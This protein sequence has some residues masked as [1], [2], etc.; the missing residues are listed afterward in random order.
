VPANGRMCSPSRAGRRKMT[1]ISLLSPTPSPVVSARRPPHQ[2]GHGWHDGRR[3]RGQNGTGQ[4]VDASHAGLLPSRRREICP[5]NVKSIAPA[6]TEGSRAGRR[7]GQ[8]AGRRERRG[9]FQ[10][11]LEDVAVSALGGTSRL[12]HKGFS[13]L[14]PSTSAGGVKRGRELEGEPYLSLSPVDGVSALTASASPPSRHHNRLPPRVSG[15]RWYCL[16]G[17]LGLHLGVASCDAAARGLAQ[18][19]AVPAQ[20]HQRPSRVTPFRCEAIDPPVRPQELHDVP[21][22][23]GECE[24]AMGS[25][26]RL[27]LREVS[28]E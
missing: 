9:A 8:P 21:V 2:R 26:V 20:L 22:V 13:A 1:T 24:D 28:R 12:P 19:G 4:P 25:D 5:Y 23:V 17:A 18:G 6:A 16:G 10:G 14:V 3:E 7:A 15:R 11:N 27:A